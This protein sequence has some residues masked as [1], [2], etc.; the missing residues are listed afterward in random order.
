MSVR[1]TGFAMLCSSS[2]QEA[3]DF[4]AHR[5]GRDACESR[6][7]FL[8]FFDGFR[9]S[10]EV[11]K[12]ELLADDDLRALIDESQV[13]RTASE[14]SRPITRSCAGRPRTPTS[15]SRRARRATVLRRVPGTWQRVMDALARPH[16]R[17]YASFE[18]HGHPTP[19][20]CIVMMGRASRPRR[21]TVDALAPSASEVGVLKVR[22]YR[23]FD[24]RRF[25][26]ALPR[27][28]GHRGARSHQGAG[29]PGEPLY[30]DVVAALAEH[31]V[32]ACRCERA[33]PP[34]LVAAATASRRRSSRPRWSRP[35]STS[36]RPSARERTSR[37]GSTTTSPTPACVDPRPPSIEPER[38][39]ARGLLRARLGWDRRRQQELDQDHR[40]GR[41][42]LRATSSTTPKSPAQSRSRTCASARSH[43]LAYLVRAGELRRRA[44]SGPLPRAHGRARH[45]AQG[46]TFL[47]NS[48]YGPSE[49]CGPSCR[50]TPGAILEREAALLRDRRGHKVAKRGRARRAHQHGD[51]DVLL[52][53]LQACLPRERRSNA[54]KAPSRRPM[55]VKGERSCAQ[56]RAVDL[57]RSQPARVP[58]AEAVTSAATGSPLVGSGR[59]PDFVRDV[60]AR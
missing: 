47:L 43:P 23:P 25:V 52:R 20:A 14:P 19:S 3:H 48:P 58:V 26:H 33:A 16:G 27:T 4:A 1:A 46:A 54:I 53:A 30:L 24:A 37:W 32:G 5:A 10:H 39:G 40:E 38:R 36:S 7:P 9:T 50:E 21:E 49:V 55:R 31:V 45:A 11:A 57:T 2:V 44:T 28:R 13:S 42:T 29:R 60:T 15:S 35:S 17:Q 8:H 59:A 41:T 18:Y 12:I 34:R 56:L 22:L 51:A 6:V